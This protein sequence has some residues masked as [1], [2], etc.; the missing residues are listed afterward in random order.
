MGLSCK[1]SLKP[2]HWSTDSTVFEEGL[3]INH[4]TP[5]RASN[6]A[7]AKNGMQYKLG[8]AVMFVGL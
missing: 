1:F 5:I 7:E 4:G 2:I 6:F 3:S 8:P